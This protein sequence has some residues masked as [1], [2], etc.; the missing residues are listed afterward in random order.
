MKKISKMKIQLTI[1]VIREISPI[2]HPQ[3]YVCIKTYTNTYMYTPHSDNA[4]QVYT[5]KKLLFVY[6]THTR[7]FIATGI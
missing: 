1:T 2:I 3:V 7:K 4:K 5:I 6:V